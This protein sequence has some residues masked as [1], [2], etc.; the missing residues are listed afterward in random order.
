MP[1]SL[2]NILLCTCED[3]MPLDPGALRR[4][5][6]AALVTSAHQLC[7]MELQRFQ[8]IAKDPASLT[9][10]CT[11]EA[12]VFSAAAQEV[13]RTTPIDFVNVRETAGWSCDAEEAGPKMAALLAA[14]A[15]PAPPM[16][17]LTLKSDGVVLIYGRDE[18]AIDAGDL[19]KAHLDITVLIKPPAALVPPRIREFPVA[20]GM[21]RSA[22]GHLGA[23]EITVD[24]FAQ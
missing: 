8:S 1:D 18:Q 4:G 12:A 21:V 7:R 19:L 6:R 24:D 17:H 3:T 16:S 10:A 2:R 15:V 20:K 13:G 9:V 14:A 23:F 5:C 22:K 11:Q